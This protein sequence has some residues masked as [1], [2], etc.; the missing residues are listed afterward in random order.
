MNPIKMGTVRTPRGRP[1][2]GTGGPNVSNNN[3]VPGTALREQVA[4]ALP[5]D[6]TSLPPIP[7]TDLAPPSIVAQEE[8]AGVRSRRFLAFNGVGLQHGPIRFEVKHECGGWTWAHYPFCGMCGQRLVIEPRHQ[9][10]LDRHAHRA[11]SPLAARRPFAAAQP[12]EGE[13]PSPAHGPRPVDQSALPVGSF[14]NP[15]WAQRGPLPGN[16]AVRQAETPV[17]PPRPIRQAPATDR[18]G[19]VFA[20]PRAAS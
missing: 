4:S 2:P 17:E 16:P 3:P 11:E 12:D 1:V 8:A 20:R 19:V 13:Q 9:E 5:P 15:V 10:L 7:L 6:E 18:P 14:H